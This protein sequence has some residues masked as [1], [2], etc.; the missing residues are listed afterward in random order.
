MRRSRLLIALLLFLAGLVFLYLQFGKEEILPKKQMVTDQKTLQEKRSEVSI[1]ETS[2]FVPTWTLSGEG[3]PEGYSRY[4]YFGLT[5]TTSGVSDDSEEYANMEGFTEQVPAGAKKLLTIKMTHTPTNL[6]VL[7]DP[8]LQ[9]S[10]I[11]DSIKAAS[12]NGFSGLVLDLELSS[13]F[14]DSLP[15]QI[16]AFVEKFYDAAKKNKLTLAL[17]IY[18]DVFYRKRPFDVD[19]LASRSDEIMVMAYDFHKSIG[20]P[21]PNFPL[22]NKEKFGYDYHAMVDDFLRYVEPHKLTV[23]FG[24]YGYDW[25]VDEKK[26]PIRQAKALSLNEIKKKYTE[27]CG[28]SNCVP[29][30]DDKATE[31]EIDYVDNGVYHIIWFEDEESAKRKTQFLQENGIGSIGYWA[32]GY[33]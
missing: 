6:T 17:T 4:I 32:Y 9:Q 26:R 31:N 23:L 24:M 28:N 14:D 25:I 29:F 15:T 18:G 3:L 2:L 13:L 33:F 11:D 22:G 12:E 30:R 8:S 16:N 20:E 19:S 27:T 1:S 10:I 5:A 7:Q 21:G